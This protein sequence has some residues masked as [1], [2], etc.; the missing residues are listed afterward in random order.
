MREC[1]A[2]DNHVWATNREVARQPGLTTHWCCARV[3]TNTSSKCASMA[4]YTLTSVASEALFRLTPW[5][6]G[7]RKPRHA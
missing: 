5:P 2:Y 7:V 1:P 6:P 3:N 4:G